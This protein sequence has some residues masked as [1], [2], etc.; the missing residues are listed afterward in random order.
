MPRTCLVRLA[1]T[2]QR[3]MNPYWSKCRDQRD[4]NRDITVGAMIAQRG[5]DV[6]KLRRA[7]SDHRQSEPVR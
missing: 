1:F 6:I 3:Q 7:G 5:S 2:D 4:A